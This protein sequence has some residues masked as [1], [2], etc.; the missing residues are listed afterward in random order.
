MST[1]EAISVH[2]YE[3]IVCEINFNVHEDR[4][5]SASAETLRPS[6]NERE[7]CKSA[8]ICFNG[9]PSGSAMDLDAN[10]VRKDLKII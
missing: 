4:P 2:K 3:Y 10:W 9:N 6:P 8:T 7:R 1:E 5:L